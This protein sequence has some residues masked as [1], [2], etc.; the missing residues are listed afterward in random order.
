MCGICGF[1]T[2]HPRPTPDE[3]L[4]RHMCGTLIHRGP[5]DEGIYIDAHAALGVRRL[6]IID[7]VT[8]H[9]PIGNEDASVWVAL[10]GE[11]YNYQEVRRTLEQQ[12]HV[13][14]TRTDT[15]VIVHAYEEYGD[16][17]V[18]HFN[19]MF[20]FALWDKPKRRLLLARDHLGIKP[21]YYWANGEHI[22]FGSELKA[23]LAH[24]D[25][26]TDIHPLALEQFLVLEYIPTPHSIFQ[27]VQ[28]LPPGH[29][30]IFEQGKVALRRYWNIPTLDIAADEQACIEQ[31]RTLIEDAIR[32]QLVGDVP[33]G[34]LLSGGIDSS[35]VVACMSRQAAAPIST[36]SIGFD[37]RSYNELPYARQV[38]AHFGCN[39][40]EEV[41]QPDIS[42]LA[43]RLV[44]QFDEPFG[45]FSIFP[46][47]LV[48]QLAGRHVKV[49]LSGD[50]GDEVFGGYDT[51]VA[52]RMDSLY[53]RL[54]AIVRSRILPQFMD[55]VAPRPQKKGIV[56]KVKRF[57]EGG[58]LP[59]AYQHTRWM[60]FM[61]EE[62]RAEL[63]RTSMPANGHAA[64]ATG[65]LLD[66]F[67]DAAQRDSLAQQQYVD[68]KTYLVD[69]ILVKVDRMS[70]A[71]SL[72]ARVPLL[73]YRLVEFAL[74]LPAAM[75]IN[76]G[77]TKRVLRSAMR[78]HLPQAV[79]TR[80]KEGFSIPIRH[81]LRHE[82]KPMMTDLLAP[83]LVNRRGYFDATTVS[84]WINEHLAARADH[85]HRL[86]GLIVFELWHQHI[87]DA[88]RSQTNLAHTQPATVLSHGQ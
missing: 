13:F 57:V 8:G 74:N 2:L 4:L 83:T 1:V 23:L 66:H 82:V 31:V 36:F 73:D 59:D 61:S 34:A 72:E 29:V 15:E 30:L 19:G 45:D 53:G 5:D 39:H 38:A 40:H 33:V 51:Y 14:Q 12:G 79:I 56:N 16:Q 46:T 41:L 48:S 43:E 58:A 28:K 85:S 3:S 76:G 11:I 60:M 35:T 21:L 24:P 42:V 88:R 62:Q 32:M 6:S 77:Q 37:D 75:K 9:Q 54:P 7:L 65:F 52:Q 17:C 67:H 18:T 84:H 22:V 71:A 68:L 78:E 70:M 44:P 10:N 50:G 25:L 64:N 80:P 87:F 69:D 81:W 49:V 20:A 55:R 63:Y 27:A 86:W 47:Y 26:P